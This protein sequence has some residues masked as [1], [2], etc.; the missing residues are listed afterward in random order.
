MNKTVKTKEEL[1]VEIEYN[2]E[3]EESLY[4]TDLSDF[5]GK[6]PKLRMFSH[7]KL[8]PGEAVDFHVHN[9]EFESY[10]ILSGKGLYDDNGTKMEVEKGAVT[11]TPS[12][13]GHGILNIGDEM[14]EFIALIIK[15]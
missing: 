4:L 1:K 5:V 7:A 11:F 2:K 8:L 13:S 3:N 15:D 14:L 10:Y 9:G 6:N 12:G